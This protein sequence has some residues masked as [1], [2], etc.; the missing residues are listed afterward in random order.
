[1][2]FFFRIILIRHINSTHLV[3]SSSSSVSFSPSVVASAYYNWGGTQ[4]VCLCRAVATPP[5]VVIMHH[6]PSL[7]MQ[8]RWQLDLR[9]P[10]TN[11]SQVSMVR[12]G[13]HRGF[14]RQINNYND[15]CDVCLRCLVMTLTAAA[16]ICLAPR[17]RRCRRLAPMNKSSLMNAKVALRLWLDSEELVCGVLN[18][19]DSRGATSSLNVKSATS[20]LCFSSLSSLFSVVGL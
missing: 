3:S 5:L 17:R 9:R 13:L 12:P 19:L 10:P 11:W 16:S 7:C 2:W 4:P 18:I 8:T 14:W 15:P 1:M 6:T 20:K